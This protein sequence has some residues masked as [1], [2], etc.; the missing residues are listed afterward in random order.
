MQA[1]APVTAQTSDADSAHESGAPAGDEKPTGSA[2]NLLALVSKALAAGSGVDAAADG[3]AA[4][5]DRHAAAD[6]HAAAADGQA[7]EP[8]GA[9]QAA[10]L[11]EDLQR[12]VL[13]SELEQQVW[14]LATVAGTW[15]S[16][17]TDARAATVALVERAV[18]KVRSWAPTHPVCAMYVP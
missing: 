10:A 8:V 11:F 18:L 4:A 1:L 12:A 2:E 13:A 15:R 7:V 6:G 16:P 5:V 9:D 17:D 14:L 3:L